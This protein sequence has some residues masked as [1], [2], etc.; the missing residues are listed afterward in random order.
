MLIKIA[1]KYLR[2]NF[3][4]KKNIDGDYNN[5]AYDL[6]ILKLVLVSGDSQ[7]NT[8]ATDISTKHV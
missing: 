6:H 1:L 7:K 8:Y 4:Q 3:Q 5:K 2:E